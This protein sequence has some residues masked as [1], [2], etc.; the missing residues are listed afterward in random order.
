MRIA[1]EYKVDHAEA[2]ESEYASNPV[3]ATEFERATA[4]AAPTDAAE[5]QHVSGLTEDIRE[6][7]TCRTEIQRMEICSP[8]ENAEPCTVRWV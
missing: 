6:E 4:G 7:N 8:S 3:A 1:E 2:M 5:H